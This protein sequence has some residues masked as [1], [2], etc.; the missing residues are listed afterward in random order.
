MFVN[1]PFPQLVVSAQDAVSDLK[2]R[3]RAQYQRMH[4]L[5]EANQAE[6]MQMLESTYTMY[7]RKN[8]QQVLQLNER[9]QEAEKLLSSVQTFFKRADGINFMKVQMHSCLYRHTDTHDSHTYWQCFY[10]VCI[11]RIKCCQSVVAH[12]ALSVTLMHIHNVQRQI[13][14]GPL[15]VC[16][17]VLLSSCLKVDLKDLCI[18]FSFSEHKTLPAANG[19]VRICS[20]VLFHLT[21]TWLI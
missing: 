21:G 14:A 2:E 13:T 17:S 5:L 9:R 7:V 16:S 3:A 20:C 19:Q 10:S 1:Q 8:S 12:K 6:T 4:A 18:L 15:S 11:H